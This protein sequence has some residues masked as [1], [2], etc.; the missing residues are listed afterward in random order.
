M[1]RSLFLMLCVLAFCGVQAASATTWYVRADGGGRFTPT[2][3]ASGYPDQQIGCDGQADVSYTAAVAAAKGATTDLH[4]AYNDMRFLWDSQ[5]DYNQLKWVIAGGDTI[6]LDNTKPWRIGYETDGTQGREPWC[7]GW[8]DGPY[9]CLNP[10]IPAG[11]EQQPT[12]ILGRNYASCNLGGKSDN[13]KMTQV[14]GGHGVWD[15]LNLSG[16]KHVQVECLD[17]TSQASCIVHGNPIPNGLACSKYNPISDYDGSG[18]GTDNQTSDILL[19]DLWIHRHTDRGIKGPIGGTVTAN[20]VNISMNGMAGWDFDDGNGT[21]N[22]NGVL[23]MSYSTIEWSG[24]NSIYPSTLPAYC[25][26]QSTG[27]YGDG[28]GTP[29]NDSM[30]VYIDHSIFRYNTQDGEDFGHIDTGSNALHITNSA[31]YANNG[32]QFK[33]GP[34]FSDV[35]FENN[36]AVA[37]CLRM[38]QPMAGIPSTYNQ[39]LGDF[40]RANDALSFNFRNGGNALFANNTIIT[41]APTTFDLTCVDGSCDASTFTLKNNIVLGL[42]NPTTWRMGGQVGGVG[43]FCGAGCNGSTAFVGTINRQNNIWSGFR[44]SCQA[45]SI[46]AAARGSATGESCADPQFN[47]EPSGFTTEAALDAF[48][49]SIASSSPAKLGGMAI[50]G[51]T[52]DYDDNVRGAAPSVGALEYQSPATLANLTAWAVNGAAP[53]AAPV[54]P[55]AP[56]PA[57]VTTPVGPVA[58]TISLSFSKGNSSATPANLT[59]TVKSLAGAANPTGAVM[60]LN[61]NKWPIGVAMLKNGSYSWQVPSILLG[62]TVYG[63]FLG[64]SGFKPSTSALTS[65]TTTVAA[66]PTK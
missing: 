51:L 26:S 6:I 36:V 14:L 37:N 17:I 48:D 27:G 11:T 46:S 41:Y 34:N 13:T 54:T 58:T 60:I 61:S 12:R 53:F 9:G 43:G 66:L 57:P 38:S 32:G 42:Q 4:C 3:Q 10:T 39:Y 15:T 2:R 19:Q 64:S 8:N 18:I 7:W 52:T 5:A 56:A 33:W 24:C 44:G 31:S 50:P 35:V 28:I 40:C 55:V 62:Q 59:A 63:A 20:R 30:S 1:K 47:N 29:A 21:P 23:K 65:G 45:N 49:F 22:I 16:A 25:Y